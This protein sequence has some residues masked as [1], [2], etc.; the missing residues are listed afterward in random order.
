MTIKDAN[1]VV[2]A[3]LRLDPSDAQA[4]QLQSNVVPISQ[5]NTGQDA[6]STSW[7][8]RLIRNQYGAPK[9]SIANA[10]LILSHD[11]DWRGVLRYNERSE[12]PIFCAPPPFFD[13]PDSLLETPRPLKDADDVRTAQW[14]EERYGLTPSLPMVHAVTNAIA[15]NASFDPVRDYLEGVAWDGTERLDTWTRDY[16][17]AQDSPYARAVGRRWMISAVARTFE[18]GSKADH[19]LVLEGGQSIG[20][21]SALEILAGEEHFGDDIPPVGSKDAQQYLGGLWIVELAE[22]DAATKAVASTLK[23]FL[24]TVKD[25]YRPAYGRRTVVHRRRCVFAGS[26]NLEEY[27]K[28][29]T[30]GRRFWP[31]ECSDVDLEALAASRDQ[32][33]AEAVV[34]YRAGERWYLDD[35]KLIASAQ[36]QQGKRLERD[37]WHDAIVEYISDPHRKFFTSSEVLEAAV[38]T[39]LGSV[40]K[41]HTNR[42]GAIMR[43]LGGWK[44]GEDSRRRRGWRRA[45]S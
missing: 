16:L 6:R 42:V 13:C 37:A 3:G 44:Y 40:T 19:V 14:L 18:P 43:S 41:V 30:G 17:G 34:A 1:D 24:T 25:R 4:V 36:L 26:V 20:K 23:R 21:S 15:M 29:S 28:D 35:P 8:Q 33:W 5:P 22:M 27:L 2:R 38:G 32:L 7:Q 9:T 10:M 31:I 39:N 45:C 12:E 11:D